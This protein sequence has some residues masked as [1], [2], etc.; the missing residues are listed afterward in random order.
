VFD[1]GGC[2]YIKIFE[3]GDN[4][5][6][7]KWKIYNSKLSVKNIFV[8]LG[9]EKCHIDVIICPESLKK[10]SIEHKVVI[11]DDRETTTTIL[12]ETLLEEFFTTFGI[13][14]TAFDQETY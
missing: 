6:S 12:D 3:E 13:D 5:M 1:E 2:I 4:V 7:F 14:Y 11:I 10:E 9:I 8:L